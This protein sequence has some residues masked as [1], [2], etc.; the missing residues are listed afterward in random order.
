MKMFIASVIVAVFLLTGALVKAQTNGLPLPVEKVLI[1]Y[2]LP[3]DSLGIFIQDVTGVRPLLTW[4]ENKSFNP[5]ST[6]K[7]LTTWVA[8]DVLGPAYTWKTF[9]YVQDPIQKGHLLGDLTFKGEGDPFLVT[10]Y[11]WKFLHGL[12]DRGLRHIAG[13]LTY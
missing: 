8:V 12:H 2:G 6:I 3:K 1:Q 9:A 7:L 5:A 13:D 10:E 11:F 4:N